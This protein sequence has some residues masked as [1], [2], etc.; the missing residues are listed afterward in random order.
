MA[1][2]PDPRKV[3]AQ[4]KRNWE[5]LQTGKTIGFRQ[6]RGVVLI[7]DGHDQLDIARLNQFPSSERNEGSLAK[8]G[9]N[10]VRVYGADLDKREFK[11]AIAEI[12]DRTVVFVD[13]L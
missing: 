4:N 12:S 6:K 9:S 5:H 11:E 2:T 13:K 1:Y 10:K 7:G 3:T 8:E